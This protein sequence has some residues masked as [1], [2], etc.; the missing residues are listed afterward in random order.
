M[1]RVFASFSYQLRMKN[2]KPNFL[3]GHK[4]FFPQFTKLTRKFTKFNRQS[5][6]ENKLIKHSLPSA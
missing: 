1:I 2:P 6:A 4:I 5:S 3:V